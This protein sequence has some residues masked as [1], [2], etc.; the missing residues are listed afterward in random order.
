VRRVRVIRVLFELSGLLQGSQ[1]PILPEEAASRLNSIN[2][3]IDDLYSA[4]DAKAE[5]DALIPDIEAALEYTREKE[6]GQGSDRQTMYN[7]D[8]RFTAHADRRSVR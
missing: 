8:R 3:G 4:Y 2:V 7:L 1:G 6:R 5:L